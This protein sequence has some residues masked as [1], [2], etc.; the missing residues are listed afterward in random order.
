MQVTFSRRVVLSLPIGECESVSTET[1]LF[2]YYIYRISTLY[3]FNISLRL[4]RETLFE[5]PFERPYRAFALF[6]AS[7]IKF[8]FDSTRLTL[9]YL[10]PSCFFFLSSS[11]TSFGIQLSLR[12]ACAPCLPSLSPARRPRS[13]SYLRA[14]RSRPAFSFIRPLLLPRP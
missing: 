1:G 12:S 8:F 3:T 2:R 11:L 13:A 4:R 6:A 10:S 7:P 9:L 5:Y 14:L